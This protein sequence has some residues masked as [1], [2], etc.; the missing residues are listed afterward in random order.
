[1]PCAQALANPDW[2]LVISDWSM[3]AFSAL[4]ALVVL[5]SI[6]RDLPFIVVSGTVGEESAVEAMRSGAND[7]V[8]KDHLGRLNPAVDRETSGGRRAARAQAR[9]RCTPSQ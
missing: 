7:Y 3:P 1:M 4:K 2:D 8:L 5:Q 6:R 9:R